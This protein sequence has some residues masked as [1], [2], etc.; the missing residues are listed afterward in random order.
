MTEKACSTCRFF[1][2]TYCAGGG[3]GDGGPLDFGECEL[4]VRDGEWRSLDEG[5][6]DDFS[7]SR[8]DGE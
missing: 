1:Q 5:V 6:A 2:R 4:G 7:C 3:A 8:W